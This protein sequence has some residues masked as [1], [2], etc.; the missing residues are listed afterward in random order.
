MSSTDAAPADPEPD[1]HPVRDR[2]ARP[3]GWRE[4]G[5]TSGGLVVMLHGLGGSRTAWEPQLTSLSL[6]GYRA[7]AWDMPGYGASDPPREWTFDGLASAAATWIRGLRPGAAHVVG[8]SLGGMVALHLALAEPSLV[9]SLVLC[10]T[11]PA[12]GLDGLT[13]SD[14]WIEARLTPIRAGATPAS[15]AAGVFEA[16]MAPGAPAAAVE[17]AAAAMARVGATAFEAAVR[18]LPSHDVRERLTEIAAPTLV[19]VGALDRETPPDYARHLANGIAGSRYIEIEGAGHISN[20]ERPESFNAAL[21][22]FLATVD[23]SDIRSA[24]F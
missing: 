22:D 11:S 5:P 15:M 18:C 23:E 13:D 10:D 8:L 3:V 4:A 20:L 7:A 19:I 17:Q 14:T 9:R 16:I 1:R 6:A 21:L 24:G 2:D 12:F